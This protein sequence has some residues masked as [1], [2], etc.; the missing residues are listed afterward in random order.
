MKRMIFFILVL[1]CSVRNASSQS[2]VYWDNSNGA[3]GIAWGLSS[4]EEAEDSAYSQCLQNGG[5]NPR[6]LA[7]TEDKGFGAVAIGADEDGNPVIAVAIGEDSEEFA[8][9]QAR[10]ECEYKGATKVSIE[11]GASWDD[12]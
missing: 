10:Y 1:T 6:L 3:V 11:I 5:L 12:E 7:S 8:N 2:A 4:Q 9:Q